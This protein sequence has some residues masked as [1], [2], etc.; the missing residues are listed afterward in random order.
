MLLYAKC[1]MYCVYVF[2]CV[3]SFFK[4]L[5]L[6]AITYVMQQRITHILTFSTRTALSF[7]LVT[8]RYTAPHLNT[9]SHV[10]CMYLY[11]SF[12]I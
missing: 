7:S 2:V 10:L 6:T 3:I 1:V 4:C 11:H 8:P 12:T 9:R 5:A